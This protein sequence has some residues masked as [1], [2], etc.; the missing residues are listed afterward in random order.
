MV[1]TKQGFYFL[2]K[3]GLYIDQ[4]MV[5]LINY[6]SEFTPIISQWQTPN[7]KENEPTMF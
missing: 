2:G 7:E 6:F 5:C 4:P 3:P 1:K